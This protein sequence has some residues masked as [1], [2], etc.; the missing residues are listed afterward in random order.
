MTYNTGESSEELRQ[1]YNPD[2]SVLRKVQNRLLEMMLYLDEVCKAIDVP[3]RLDGGNVLGAVRHQG[4]I[5]WDDDVDIV[6]EDQYYDKLCSYLASHPHPQFVFQSPETDKG[7]FRFWNTI[8]DTKSEYV[9]KKGNA[10]NDA[11]E[12]RGLQVDIFR[13]VQV[14]YPSSIVFPLS[15]SN[16]GL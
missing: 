13:Y 7:Y 14:R 3:Y 5:P 1:K 9:H 15:F 4:F 16:M 12:Y 11:F 6:V 10:L 8:R 2:G